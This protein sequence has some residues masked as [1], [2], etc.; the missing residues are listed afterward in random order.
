VTAAAA[1]GIPARNGRLAAIQLSSP[2]ADD[3]TQNPAANFINPVRFNVTR[4]IQFYTE[5]LHI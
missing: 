4:I 5:N 2:D 3:F 1:R